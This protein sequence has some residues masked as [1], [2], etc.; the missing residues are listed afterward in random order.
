VKWLTGSL[1]SVRIQI[2]VDPVFLSHIVLIYI[3]LYSSEEYFRNAK[4]GGYYIFLAETECGK[5]VLHL[6]GMCLVGFGNL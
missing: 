2:P 5:A 6:R 4:L 1:T 3:F